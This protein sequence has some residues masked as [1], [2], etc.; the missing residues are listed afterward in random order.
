L[1]QSLYWEAANAQEFRFGP[2]AGFYVN[3]KLMKTRFCGKR[4]MDPKY[5]FYIGGMAE[6][7]SV[8]NFAFRE[9]FYI[10]HLEQ[11]KNDGINAGIMFVEQTKINL[12]TLLVPISAKYFIT[13]GFSV[14][15]GTNVGIILSAKQK[16]VIGSDFWFGDSEGRY[17]EMGDI[18]DLIKL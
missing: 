14:A 16:T 18:K 10:L 5:T 13:E 7:K 9:K 2:K 6:Y 8:I 4:N 17:Q 15:A 3:I 1:Q 11:K 12:G